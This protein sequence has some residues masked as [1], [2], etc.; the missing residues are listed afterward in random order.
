MYYLYD[1]LTCFFLLFTV[2]KPSITSVDIRMIKPQELKYKHPK[3]P[4]M[5]TA[6]SEVYKGEY[7]GFT[8]AIKRYIDPV[9]TNPG[10]VPQFSCILRKKCFFYIK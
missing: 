6:T 4:F 3:K 2:N 7:R 10:S 5:E 8:V 9:N 1:L